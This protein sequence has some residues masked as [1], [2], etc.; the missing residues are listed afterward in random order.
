MLFD[1]LKDK[2]HEKILIRLQLLES[3]GPYIP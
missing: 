1:H 2:C 3:L